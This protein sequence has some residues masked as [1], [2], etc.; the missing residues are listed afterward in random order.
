MIKYIHSFLKTEHNKNER[1]VI[2]VENDVLQNLKE[3]IRE[4]IETIEGY[5]QR[6]MET[7][8]EEFFDSCNNRFDSN[9]I[10]RFHCVSFF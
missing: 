4:E 5:M 9:Q 10:L 7:G 1:R 6:E 8:T 2:M 3:K